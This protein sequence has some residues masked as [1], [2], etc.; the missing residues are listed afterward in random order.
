MLPGRMILLFFTFSILSVTGA[1]HAGFFDQLVNDAKKTLEDTIQ[2]TNSSAPANNNGVETGA[3][4]V[5]ESQ[6]GQ[7][8]SV[9]SANTVQTVYD[10]GQVKEIQ[11]P[12]HAGG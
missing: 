5:T 6:A 10:K 11:Q 2:N 3:H 1:A 8:S 12:E 7:S 4:S 9:T